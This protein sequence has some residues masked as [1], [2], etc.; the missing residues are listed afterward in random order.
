MRLYGVEVE[1]DAGWT[2]LARH[3]TELRHIQ[4]LLES[5]DREANESIGFRAC[6]YWHDPCHVVLP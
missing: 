3:Y 4:S 1:V 6:Q 2:C 5:Y